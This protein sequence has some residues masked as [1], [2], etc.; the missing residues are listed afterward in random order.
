M[1]FSLQDPVPV[2]LWVHMHWTEGFLALRVT[3]Y[4]LF[5]QEGT[6]WFIH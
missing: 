3:E 1:T 4:Q 6:E 5:T 2:S